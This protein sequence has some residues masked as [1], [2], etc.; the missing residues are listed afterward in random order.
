MCIWQWEQLLMGSYDFLRLHTCWYGVLLAQPLG[1]P[2]IWLNLP[3][4]SCGND[5]YAICQSE[6]WVNEMWITKGYRFQ[7]L[8]NWLNDIRCWWLFWPSGV[9]W[10]ALSYVSRLYWWVIFIWRSI[11]RMHRLVVGWWE[12]W[13]LWGCVGDL[14][15]SLPSMGSGNMGLLSSS[16]RFDPDAIISL[17]AASALLFIHSSISSLLNL[18]NF[19]C[20]SPMC[21]S[22]EWLHF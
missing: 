5:W 6:G 22:R 10:D 11:G 15:W 13:G 20:H 1:G 18:E 7:P 3:W 14:A 19:L 4:F 21:A 12:R 2:L 8:G 9:S 17:N 16:P